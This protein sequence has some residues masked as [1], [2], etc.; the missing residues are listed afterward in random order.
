MSGSAPHQLK[1]KKC[2][3]RYM[4][5]V[6]SGFCPHAGNRAA[7]AKLERAEDPRCSRCTKK[8]KAVVAFLAIS[9]AVKGFESERHRGQ[10]RGVRLCKP[11]TRDLLLAFGE[12]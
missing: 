12:K 6:Q 8:V 3:A 10:A 11:C 4:P 1:C 7:N 2:G 5:E 9:K